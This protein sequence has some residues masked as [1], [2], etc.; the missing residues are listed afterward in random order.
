MGD[1]KG[2]IECYDLALKLSP[3]DADTY[4]NKGNALSA[5]GDNK[6]ALKCYDLALELRP[7]HADTYM[8]KGNALSDLG[9]K[10]G[11]IECYDLA[12]KLRPNHALTY[13]N[14]GNALNALGQ[15]EAALECFN[16]AYELSRI[17]QFTGLSKINIAY[18]NRVLDNER[19][20]LLKKIT[21]LG[22][23]KLT[24]HGQKQFKEKVAELNEQRK[25]LISEGTAL[26][27][28]KAP[29]LQR[30]ATRIEFEAF[31][32]KMQKQAEEMFKM[33]Q[34]L[35]QLAKTQ[36]AQI[37]QLE[38][39]NEHIE[40]KT[41]EN[42]KSLAAHSAIIKSAG[43]DRTAGIN[44]E[45]EALRKESPGL[46]EYYNTFYRTLL[47][48]FKAYEL[49]GTGMV[50]GDA[51]AGIAEQ[52]G[53]KQ[54]SDQV[55]EWLG[56][57]AEIVVDLIKDVPV[58]GN[59]VGMVDTL[60]EAGYSKIKELRLENRVNSI[61]KVISKARNQADLEQI[62]QNTALAIAKQVSKKGMILETALFWT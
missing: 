24:D 23:V 62:V 28:S 10:K 34:M 48:Y 21:E 41:N 54:V 13:C 60:V 53:L 20:A 3:N 2:A 40:F 33:N 38:Y 37:E 5:L 31:K 35:M 19:E 18:V 9:D 1:N 58:I 22:R 61:N 50:S 14:K 25:E 7:N 44:N 26:L 49:L 4:M 15:E 6:G 51:S 59:I 46:H 32:E 56:G 11:A 30:S 43:V 55:A 27:N 57:G 12:L 42:S 17:G 36:A 39:K 45:V 8:N 52:I 16:K 29:L 47:N